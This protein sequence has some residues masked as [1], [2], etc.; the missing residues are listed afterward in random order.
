M[1]ALTD[2]DHER[3]NMLRDIRSAVLKAIEGLRAQGIIK[4]SLEAQVTFHVA[5]DAPFMPCFKSLIEELKSTQQ[6]DKGFF[7]EFFIVSDVA[8]QAEQSDL[9]S[10]ELPGLSVLINKAP[11][12]KCNRCWQWKTDVN[13]KQ[14]CGRCQKIVG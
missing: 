5:A 11:G 8:L 7:E 2:A 12:H 4:H 6:G 9:E 1:P 3:W 14:L 10:S 13:E